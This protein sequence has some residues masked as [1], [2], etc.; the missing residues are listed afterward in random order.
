MQDQVQALEQRGVP[1]DVPG[2]DARRRRGAAAHERARP[3]GASSCSTWRP[4]G[5]RSRASASCCAACACRSWPSTRRTASA[6]GAT[7]SGP[8]TCRSA[9]CSAACARRASWP[10]RRRR[11]RSCATRSWRG[12]ASARTRRRSSRGFARPNLDPARGRGGRA[13]RSA[14]RTCD[15]HVGTRRWAAGPRRAARRSCTR[16]RVA[17][18]RGGGR[19]TRRVGWRAARYHAGLRGRGARRRRSAR[20]PTARST[21]WWPPIAFGMGIDRA[22]VRAVMHLAPPGS[23]EAY[24]Q[25]VGRAGRDG[26]PA[27]GLLLVSPADMPLRRRLLESSARASRRRRAR[28]Q[29]GA[30]PRAD[31]LG[32]G[33]QLPSRRHPALLRRRGRNAG[34]CGQCD[35]CEALAGGGDE[36]DQEEVTADRAQG[37]ER[38]RTGA[39]SLWPARRRCSCSRA[40]DD[41]RLAR[42]VPRSDHDVRRA[43][44]RD[45]RVA[46]EA[47]PPVRDGRLGAVHGRR[48]SRRAISREPAGR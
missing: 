47:A 13:R 45:R 25:E 10:A 30:V 32:R 22:D 43:R 14:T 37:A 38:R 23:I 19:A 1:G 9:S 26:A 4:S 20:S 44:E 6:S 8:N 39:R 24:Y 34:G 17:Q 2:V 11:R 29:V 7:T 33:R 18:T 36:Q 28:A 5:L 46:D 21:S 40:R 31:A 41:P 27:W 35:V 3:A 16:R 42:G 15:A 48:P 12:W